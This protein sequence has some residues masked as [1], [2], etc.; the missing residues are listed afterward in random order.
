MGAIVDK[1]LNGETEEFGEKVLHG[2]HNLLSDSETAHLFSH[3]ALAELID[4]IDDSQL[5]IVTMGYGKHEPNTWVGGHRGKLSGKEL[6]DAVQEGRLWVNLRHAMNTEAEYINAQ[7]KMFGHLSEM[8]PGFKPYSVY[9]SILISSPNAKVYYH[10]DPGEVILWHLSGEKRVTCYPNK[11]PFL[12]D[13]T[14]EGLILS[15]NSEELPYEDWYDEH[16][17]AIDLKPGQFV[18]WPHS[19]PHK[20]DNGNSLNV[21][22]T[23]EFTT[24]AS[25]MRHGARYANGMLRRRFNANPSFDKMRTVHTMAKFA[26]S[27]PMRALKVKSGK[28]QVHKDHLVVDRE[29]ENCLNWFDEPIP[30]SE[31]II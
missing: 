23:T 9:G 7:D 15:E 16:A 8:M 27:L 2:A 20:V 14:Y 5:D 28:E 1:W 3:D 30:R 11:A 10:A 12:D 4:T 24:L 18:S 17:A 25:R 26:A 29:V 22:I 13:E 21:S 6:L 19:S 31:R